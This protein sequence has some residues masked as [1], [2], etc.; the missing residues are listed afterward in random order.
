MISNIA[1][2]G[3]LMQ[4]CRGLESTD[5]A[6]AN[7]M[8]DGLTFLTARRGGITSEDVWS[9]PIV[10]WIKLH[11]P[12]Q[13]VDPSFVE[14]MQSLLDDMPIASDSL[15]GRNS[16]GLFQLVIKGES[17]GLIIPYD[18]QP[19]SYSSGGNGILSITCNVPA[20]KLVYFLKEPVQDHGLFEV[21]PESRRSVLIG[22]GFEYKTASEDV[23]LAR[24][25]ADMAFQNLCNACP[26][27]EF[28]ADNCDIVPDFLKV[29]H[30]ESIARVIKDCKITLGSES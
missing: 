25:L 17:C 29:S 8:L 18:T 30:W 2:V 24:R 11:F 14:R 15:D 22:K 3:E 9:D 5:S 1:T 10:W 27:F 6:F 4:Y 19:F 13:G 26:I 16:P 28:F 20:G 12:V 21:W 23:C 7:F